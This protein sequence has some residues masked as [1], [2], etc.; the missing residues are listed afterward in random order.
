M[1]YAHD[2]DVIVVHTPDRL[3]RTVRDTLNLI[4]DLTARRVG[5]RNL[6]NPSKS[7]LGYPPI[8]HLVTDVPDS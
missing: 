3:G 1:G 5:I 8:R 2:G 7:A 6:A 4:H